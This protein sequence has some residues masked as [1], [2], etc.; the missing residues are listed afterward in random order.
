MGIHDISTQE[1]T[2][3]KKDKRLIA[4][5]LMIMLLASS[6]FLTGC[7]GDDEEED[8]PVGGDGRMVMNLD[9]E[10]DSDN[11]VMWEFEQDGDLFDCEDVF[12]VNE[13]YD[14]PGTGELHSFTLKPLR[15]G[16][17]EV[18]FINESTSVT[19]TYEVEISENL[20]KI[21]VLSSSGESGGE[22]V[23][24]PNPILERN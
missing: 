20:D 15:P 10:S 2:S 19:Y 21:T 12:L 17:T 24:P 22:A 4:G 18:K 14:G 3:M 6:A 8:I 16:T 23:D 13:G 1:E 5:L 7:F 11:G 9:L